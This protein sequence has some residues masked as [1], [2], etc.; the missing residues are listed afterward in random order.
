ML[1]R[2]HTAAFIDGL[3][4]QIDAGQLSLEAGAKE[5]GKPSLLGRL[6]AAFRSFWFP[7]PGDLPLF[8]AW[9]RGEHN[10]ESRVVGATFTSAP[11]DGMAGITSWPLAIALSQLLDGRITTVGVHPPETVIEP[12]HFFNMLAQACEPPVD[13]MEELVIQDVNSI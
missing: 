4:K 1:L 13:G 8:F 9:A 12:E 6:K 3:R 10:G 7:G 5:I 2:K 11:A